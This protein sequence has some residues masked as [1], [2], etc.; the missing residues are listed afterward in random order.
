MR[1][2]ILTLVIGASLLLIACQNNPKTNDLDRNKTEEIETKFD[3]KN[4]D[5]VFTVAKNYF[6][7]NTVTSLLNPKIETAEKFTEIF[8]MGSTMG[9]EGKP[10]EIDFQKQYVIAVVLPETEMK[11]TMSPVSLQKDEKGTITL[12]YKTT[13][14]QKQLFTSRP[15][16]L[17]IVD[18]SEN[19]IIEVKEQN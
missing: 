18:N 10:T 2:P 7:N 14:G 19:G 12:L 11:T 5:I 15:N 6:V 13:V 16:F 17:I 4:T 8:G 3:P 9:D 1:K